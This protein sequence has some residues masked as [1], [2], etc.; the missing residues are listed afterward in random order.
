MEVLKNQSW[1]FC[2]MEIKTG[3]TKQSEIQNVYATPSMYNNIIVLLMS[4]S[5]WTVVSEFTTLQH[6]RLNDNS[7]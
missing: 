1:W 6:N 4:G 7:I 3:R 5:C 2:C